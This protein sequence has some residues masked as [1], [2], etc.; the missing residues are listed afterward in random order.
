MNRLFNILV[1]L[2]PIIGNGQD[3][4]I[5]ESY[6]DSTTKQEFIIASDSLT[7]DRNMGDSYRLLI[8]KNKSE[9]QKIYLDVNRS[10]DFAYTINSEFYKI[11]DIII[12]QGCAMFYIYDPIKNQI[13]DQIFPDYTN[14][15]FSDGQG[16]FISDLKIKKNGQ[17][18]EL[19]VNECGIRR[20]DINDIKRIKEI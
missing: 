1:F 11:H 8:I 14:C 15:D 4:K 2:I 20:F 7:Y 19:K 3:Y 9:I 17:I 16:S 13:S 12:I 6:I 10:P 5:L 18:L